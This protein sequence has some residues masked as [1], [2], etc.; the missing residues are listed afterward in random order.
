MFSNYVFVSGPSESGKSGGVNYIA[1]KFSNVKHLKIRNIFREVYEQSSSKLSYDEWYNVNR[2]INLKQFWL[3]FISKVNEK[4]ESGF[5]IVIL[6]T[7][8]GIDDIQCLY[9]ILGEKL[10][11]LYVDADE[12][13]RVIREFN[14]LR[15]DSTNSF[16][17]ADM[18][19]T[20]EEVKENTMKKDEKK[21][22]I[23]CLNIQNYLKKK[24]N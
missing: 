24:G 8:Y 1:S 11:I 16:R 19:I 17:K 6:D 10:S 9:D 20:I 23:K 15:T 13:L 3:E 14:R 5:D 4:Y 21:K 2:E 12:S 7:M 18:S 22:T